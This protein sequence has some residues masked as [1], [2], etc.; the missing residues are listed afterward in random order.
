MNDERRLH[1]KGL[2]LVYR[3]FERADGVG[4]GGFV[5]TDMTVADLQE[6][7]P[8]WFRSNRL[9]DDANGTRHAACDRP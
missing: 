6:G 4:I 9:T 1:R 7:Q 8:A 2:D 3:F 5:K